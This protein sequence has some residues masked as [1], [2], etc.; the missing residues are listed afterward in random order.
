MLYSTA[1]WHPLINGYSDYIPPDFRAMV[2]PVSSFPNRESFAI[3]KQLGARYV[4]FHWHWY[5]HRQVV[6]VQQRIEEFRD[7]LRPVC[8]ENPVWLFEIVAWPPEH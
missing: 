5:D 7:Y 6:V 1:H 3:L 2:I 8:L 4:I